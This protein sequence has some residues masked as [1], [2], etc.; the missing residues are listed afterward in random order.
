MRDQI[1]ARADLAVPRNEVLEIARPI[2][3]A[4]EAA[5]L[6]LC[7][8]RGRAAGGAQGGADKQAA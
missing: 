1:G 6:A 8:L 3:V 5:Y 2:D 4:V 7:L